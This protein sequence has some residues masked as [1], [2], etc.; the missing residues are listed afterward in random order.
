MNGWSEI[1]RRR[2]PRGH[3]ALLRPFKQKP[4]D[5]SSYSESRVGGDRAAGLYPSSGAQ[6]L[7]QSPCRR[8]KQLFSRLIRCVFQRLPAQDDYYS[9]FRGEFRAGIGGDHG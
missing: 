8:A 4:S 7:L 9:R 6:L 2:K 3:N 5:L 1:V